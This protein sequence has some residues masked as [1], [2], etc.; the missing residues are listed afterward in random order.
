MTSAAAPAA[1]S[2]GVLAQGLGLDA[3][4]VDLAQLLNPAKN[5]GEF[6][7]QRLKALFGLGKARQPRHFAHGVFIYGHRNPPL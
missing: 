3:F 1:A 6:L 2:P 4:D 7:R 5:A